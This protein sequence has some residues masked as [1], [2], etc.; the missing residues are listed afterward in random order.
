MAGFDRKLASDMKIFSPRLLIL[1]L[2]LP[3]AAAA[4]SGSNVYIE[5]R[6]NQLQQSIT[7]LTGQLEQLQYQNQQL[8]EQMEK[9]RTD[10]DFRLDQVEK[11]G[12]GGPR[13]SGPA[14]PGP[15]PAT[16]SRNT[17]SRPCGRKADRSTPR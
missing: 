14:S 13:P 8:Q 6:L 15:A 16:G 4:Q 2:A 9:M 1:A 12:K 11:G 3:S 7:R 17:S 5:D 10:Y